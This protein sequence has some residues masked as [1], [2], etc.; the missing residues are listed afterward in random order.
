MPRNEYCADNELYEQISYLSFTSS[1][2]SSKSEKTKMKQILKKAIAEELSD[3]QK[4]CLVEYYLNGKKMNVI[5]SELNLNPSTV[6]RHIKRAREKLRHI[7]S[8]Y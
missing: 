6:T 4:L 3:M 1:G 2:S 7:A 5:A 8:Y